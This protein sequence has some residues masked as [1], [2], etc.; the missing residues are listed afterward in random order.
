M[1]KERATLKVSAIV[2][3]EGQL[4]WLPANP[5]QW[6]QTD[7]DRT[8]NSILE[9]PDFLEDR[10]LL[11]VP[12]DEKRWLVFAGNLRREGAKS[13]KVK[14]VPCVIYYPETEEDH[15]TIKRR[16]MKDNGSFGAWDYDTLANEW[17]DL[18]LT[19][20][21]VPAWDADGI[22]EGPA[23]GVEGE[24]AEPPSL[25]ERFV[26]PPLSIL[27]TRQ[28][29]WQ[30]RKR[31][32]RNIIGDYGE[33]R[34]NTLF[35]SYE[36][37][38]P[39]LYAATRKEGEALGIGFKEYFEKYIPEEVKERE[40]KKVFSQGVSIL[41]PVMAEVIIRWFSIEGRN[42]TFD[43]FAG[44]SVFGCVSS[45][46][47]NEFVGI[48]IRQEQADL[49]NSRVRGTLASYICD[50]GQNV[51]KH[52]PAESQDLLFSCPPYYDLEKYSDLENDASNQE[53]YEDFIAILRNAFTSAVSCLKENRFAVIVVG[54]IRD[55]KTGAY[56][57]FVGDI[58][59]I[60]K[61]AGLYF[62]N[63]IIL[64]NPV[65]TA[66]VRAAG[67]M[68]TR[69]ISK[70]HQNILVFYKGNPREIR[71]HYKKIEYASEDL[72]SFGVDYGE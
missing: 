26:V 54:E 72:E 17:G 55:D 1:R 34:N 21:G 71:K 28:G 50:D 40:M 33:S 38:Y 58:R 37:K 44:D 20:W 51:A 19:D 29:Y 41:D 12:L 27:D 5:R 45:R 25:Q 62:Y 35:S 32:W 4:P 70:V 10:P 15:L 6:T 24:T 53:T 67:N 7:I 16:A 64:I 42:K 22:D 68:E 31:A 46:L 9:D 36:Q 66:A 49:N 63:E 13:G 30:E 8:R 3:N 43:C 48:E 65:G 11:V 47:G 14:E 61:E 2:A 59:S 60:F 57:D 18:P 69:K 39:E 56:R 52:I 23:G